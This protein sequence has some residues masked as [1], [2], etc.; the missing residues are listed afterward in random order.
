MPYANTPFGSRAL[1]RFVETGWLIDDAKCRYTGPSTRCRLTA[2]GPNF[3]ELETRCR[4]RVGAGPWGGSSAWRRCL[5]R[6]G[7]GRSR[8]SLG[9][10]GSPPYD[11]GHPCPGREF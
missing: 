8:A 11:R 6:P 7:R 9:A 3:E 2:L 1:A 4:R 10:F 5:T